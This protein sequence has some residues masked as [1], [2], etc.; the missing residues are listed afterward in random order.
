MDGKTVGNIEVPTALDKSETA[1]IGASL[2]TIDRIGP[3]EAE[4]KVEQIKDVRED[5]RKTIADRAKALLEG[6]DTD[7]DFGDFAKSVKEETR[8]AKIQE[9]GDEKL[10]AGDLS[11]EEVIVVEGRADVVNLLKNRVNNVI[12]MDG[13]KL[14]KEI[15]KLGE[16][17]E[18]TLFIDGD[19]GG[20][21]IANN[22]IENAKV[23]YVAVA[24]DGKEVEELAGKEILIALRK[25][26]PVS[27]YSK[28]NGNG[29]G[30]SSYAPRGVKETKEEVKDYD[31]DVKEAARGVY[32]KIK[33]TRV[34]ALVDSNFDIIRKV[35]SREISRALERSKSGVL[36]IVLDGT[37]T[38][39]IMKV[40]GEN[41]VKHL[42]ATNFSDVEDTKINLISL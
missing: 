14:P 27:E 26:V 32:A 30:K 37:A 24:P 1:L 39:T 10:P 22:V 34:A 33:G 6:L 41:G 5:K 35:G 19:R 21:L 23:K 7:K 31:G 9:Y 3:T 29:M 28:W 16:E 17:K 13:A 11:G 40:C 8:A 18:I 20:K 36:G 12:G 2:E 42:A 38:K 15:A 4:I 25:K